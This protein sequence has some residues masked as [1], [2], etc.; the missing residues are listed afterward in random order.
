MFCRRKERGKNDV[1]KI[2]AILRKQ[3]YNEGRDRMKYIDAYLRK[4]KPET[5]MDYAPGEVP[6]KT[7]NISIGAIHESPAKTNTISTI[8]P[9]KISNTYATS[10][11]DLQNIHRNRNNSTSMSSRPEQN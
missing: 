3:L 10:N 9:A 1:A 8:S 5:F 7:E 2:I 6:K 11:R 4:K